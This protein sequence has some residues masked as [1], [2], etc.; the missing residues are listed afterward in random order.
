M[1]AP[2]PP[3]LA[4]A[5]APA[6][7]YFEVANAA[8]VLYDAPSERARKLFIVVR[9]T[10]LE[11]VAVINKWVKVRDLSGDVLWIERGDLGPAQHVVAGT[12]AALRRTPQANGELIAQVE[13]GVLLEVV[14]AGAPAGWLHVRH[15]DGSIGYVAAAETW[16][17]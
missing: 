7:R 9:G 2:A 8:A 16:G 17:R 13:R 15:R 6:A 10:P 5:A 14:D 1:L 12:L 3:A 11:Q 4:Q